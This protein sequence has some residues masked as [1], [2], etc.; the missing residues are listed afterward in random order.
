MDSSTKLEFLT[1]DFSLCATEIEP[2]TWCKLVLHCVK[3]CKPHLKYFPNQLPLGQLLNCYLGDYNRRITPP[4]VVTLPANITTETKCIEITELK[5]EYVAHT[6][7]PASHHGA[8][9]WKLIIERKLLL[10]S[11]GDLLLWTAGYRPELV[12]GLGY[13]AHREG[14]YY[15]AKSSVFTLVSCENL[16]NLLQPEDRLG[17]QMIEA[18]SAL[19]ESGVGDRRQKLYSMEKL[20]S[21]LRSVLDRIER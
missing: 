4:E 18:I 2:E 9:D 6:P 19:V 11:K 16:G 20:G 12:C 21:Q 1:G 3:A 5:S 7:P 14:T 13:R 10:T 8:Y 17:L 15:N